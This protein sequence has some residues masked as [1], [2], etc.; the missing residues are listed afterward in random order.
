VLVASHSR[1]LNEGLSKSCFTIPIITT[2]A[3]FAIEK[4]NARRKFV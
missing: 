1:G 2:S 4:G 3:G